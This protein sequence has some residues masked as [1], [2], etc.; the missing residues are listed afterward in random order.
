[1]PDAVPPAP[2]PS[3]PA[4]APA[5]AGMSAG[6]GDLFN[7]CLGGSTQVAACGAVPSDNLSSRSPQ[8]Q[9]RLRW[10]LSGFPFCPGP[11]PQ[12]ERNTQQQGP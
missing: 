6:A 9:L 4:L 10:L 12:A 1:L 7:P 2:A 3:H 11:E 5:T 8:A